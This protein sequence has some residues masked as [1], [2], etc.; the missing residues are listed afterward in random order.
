M[1]R[2]FDIESPSFGRNEGVQFTMMGF[3]IPYGILTQGSIFQRVKIP[4]D[5]GMI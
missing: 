5:T 2:G 3:K 1:D 4:Y